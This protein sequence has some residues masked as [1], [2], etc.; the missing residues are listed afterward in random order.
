MMAD[1]NSVV[2]FQSSNQSTSHIIL[3]VEVSGGLTVI[4][5][6]QY[7]PFF[8]DYDHYAPSL[9]ILPNYGFI[10]AWRGRSANVSNTYQP[11]AKAY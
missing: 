5:A 4:S 1:G 10:V 6:T 3:G 8:M 11:Y 9:A 7:D 2:A